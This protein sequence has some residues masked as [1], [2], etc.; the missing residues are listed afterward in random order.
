MLKLE[1]IS[2]VRYRT[3]I[4]WN[5]GRH[6]P[7]LVD[8]CESN[9]IPLPKKIGRQWHFDERILPALI[10]N[11]QA[12]LPI[13]VPAGFAEDGTRLQV[14]DSQP[15]DLPPAYDV[16]AYARQKQILEA[17]SDAKGQVTLQAVK[18][19]R[20][21]VADMTWNQFQAEH[22]ESKLARE[23]MEATSPKRR[24][25]VMNVVDLARNVEPEHKVDEH[26]EAV[27]GMLGF[28]KFPKRRKINEVGEKLSSLIHGSTSSP[29][30]APPPPSTPPVDSS[31][32]A[33]D[34]SP[35][36]PPAPPLPMD[37]SL[38]N[39]TSA[40][41]SQIAHLAYALHLEWL[42]ILGTPGDRTTIYPHNVPSAAESMQMIREKARLE[43]E[44]MEQMARLD[45]EKHERELH[46][47][48]ETARLDKEKHERE[49]NQ[50]R[51]QA[52]VDLEKMNVEFKH[53]IDVIE[54]EGK[55]MQG[56]IRQEDKKG[57][58]N[59]Y[60]RS[61]RALHK[62][63]LSET[64][65]GKDEP[66]VASL[67]QA[68]FHIYGRSLSQM[69]KNEDYRAKLGPM[70]KFLRIMTGHTPRHFLVQRGNSS[71]AIETALRNHYREKFFGEQNQSVEP[72]MSFLAANYAKAAKKFREARANPEFSI[73]AMLIV[74]ESKK[75]K[76]EASKKLEQFKPEAKKIMEKYPSTSEMTLGQFHEVWQNFN[77][78]V[79][80]IAP[81]FCDRAESELS[82]I[83]HPK[84]S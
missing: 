67:I 42:K 63:N 56:Y 41:Q 15:S 58:P 57:N 26:A 61:F 22:H 1:D 59:S 25:M 33:P 38:P 54:K 13:K 43:K 84:A 47:M 7:W 74:D 70:G 32:P 11:R 55:K 31:P 71:V 39:A 6:H 50:M 53:R 69:M 14:P 76:Q 72:N 4:I 29:E 64:T 9:K 16:A 48:K 44:N 60:P 75:K 19:A 51:E 81:A 24:H 8:Y 73:E 68:A 35:P 34:S 45:K 40:P 78:A 80:P 46:N 3:H 66:K 77:K 2:T 83:L 79:R 21:H 17:N 65:N 27:T 18:E 30:V 5:H 62:L 82:S 10:K 23:A 28:G 49:M 20:E 12:S 36:A 37:S 52:R